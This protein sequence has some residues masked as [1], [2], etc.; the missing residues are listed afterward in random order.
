VGHRPRLPTRPTTP[1]HVRP[2]QRHPFAAK[3]H[4]VHRWTSTIIGWI[5]V[6]LSSLRSRRTN[7]AP[8]PT[9]PDA[10][11][12]PVLPRGGV[13]PDRPG[14][15]AGVKPN[16]PHRVTSNTSR[17]HCH[18]S[19]S[20]PPAV[21]GGPGTANCL[22]HRPGTAATMVAGREPGRPPETL[23]NIMTVP[24]DNQLAVPGENPDRLR[25][26]LI[27]VVARLDVGAIRARYGHHMDQ[28]TWA[29]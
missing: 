24:G 20:E 15:A 25:G 18:P 11:L 21:P 22:A 23:A 16:R 17:V 14:S 26:N 13:R 9:V 1:R 8:E 10:E 28:S 27:P 7:A 5:R 4:G 2:R 3:A 6:R 12:R 29:S 19:V